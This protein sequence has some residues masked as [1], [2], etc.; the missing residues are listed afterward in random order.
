[1]FV[2]F[3]RIKSASMMMMSIWPVYVA[4]LDLYRLGFADRD[5]LPFEKKII[6]CQWRIEVM[7]TPR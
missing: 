2:C 6:T 4:M 5:N 1:M 7:C 3:F